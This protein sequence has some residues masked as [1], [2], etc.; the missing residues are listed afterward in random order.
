MA[1]QGSKIFASD[2]N[3]LQSTVSTVLGT[4][5]SYYGYNQKVISSQ[6]T[7]IGGKYLP[8]KLSDWVN[9]R[10]D[11][12]NAYLHQ[13]SPGNLTIPG[14]PSNTNKVT[15]ADYASYSA[16]CNAIYAN[17][18]ITPSGG[19]ASLATL[20]SSSRFT[21]WNGTITHTVTLTFNTLAAAR[22]FFN[23]GSNIQ[24]TASLSGYGDTGPSTKDTDWNTLLTGIGTITMNYASTTSTGSYTQ[25]ASTVGYYQLTTTPQLIFQ[26]LTASPTY[27]PNQYDIY[28]SVDSSGT[29]ITFSIK[30]ADLSTGTVDENIQ[31]TLTSTVKSL[32]SSGTNVSVALPTVVY[33]GP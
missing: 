2:Y 25:R 28:A 31:G 33:T 19:Q 6:L 17:P 15:A 7:S 5:T 32:Y 10:T 9:L 30:F 22:A 26:K 20:C 1:T 11:I 24:F 13:G 27:T 14:I 12:V 8:I 23:S 16:L 3:I 18:T 29:V 4:G 21:Q